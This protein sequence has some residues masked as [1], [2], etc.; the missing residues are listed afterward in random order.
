MLL[1]AWI[2]DRV[3]VGR[4]APVVFVSLVLLGLSVLFMY[5]RVPVDR[6]WAV[7]AGL[8][9]IGFF[10]YGPQ[11][12]LA[13]VSPVDMSSKRVAGAAIGFT[14]FLS[15]VGATISMT[16]TGALKDSR[17]GWEGAF[18]FWACAAFTGALLCLPLWYKAPVKRAKT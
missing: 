2:S 6:P 13:G 15:Y 1:C 3:F 17:W 10:T 14:G 7:G 12:L 16:V 9:L 11:L 8:G 4:R 18:W 5:Y